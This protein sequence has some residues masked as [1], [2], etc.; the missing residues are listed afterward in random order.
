MH[1]TWKT[2]LIRNW[3]WL[4]LTGFLTPQY[5]YCTNTQYF[6]TFAHL[7]ISRLQAHCN[8]IK[9]KKN[10]YVDAKLSFEYWSIEYYCIY[11]LTTVMKID[12]LD[13]SRWDIFH[14]FQFVIYHL[15]SSKIILNIILTGH[16]STIQVVTLKNDK[17]KWLIQ[18]LQFITKI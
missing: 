2:L 17:D 13:L 9:K 12:S 18:S 4:G 16:P 7:W 5:V 1:T 6:S 15:L 8:T 3:L 10:L 14:Y 11:L